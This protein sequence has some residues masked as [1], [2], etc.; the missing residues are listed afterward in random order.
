MVLDPLDDFPLLSRRREREARKGG[1]KEMAAAAGK[2]GK[3][4]AAAAESGK[5]ESHLG[6]P[7][8][9]SSTSHFNQVHKHEIECIRIDKPTL[10]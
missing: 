7:D 2:R 6:V 10:I 9:I 8:Y 1:R 5:E 3:A 4:S